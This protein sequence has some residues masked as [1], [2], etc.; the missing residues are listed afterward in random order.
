MVCGLSVHGCMYT[1]R[2]VGSC[3]LY[4]RHEQFRTAA[5]AHIANE[6]EG[7]LDHMSNEPADQLHPP[8]LIPRVHNA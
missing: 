6:W 4:S 8:G 1:S 3:G 2:T 5:Y 7:L